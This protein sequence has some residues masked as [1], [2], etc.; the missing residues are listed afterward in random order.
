MNAE[1]KTAFRFTSR[2]FSYA[3]KVMSDQE[4][5]LLNFG[6]RE[7]HKKTSRASKTGQASS[8]RSL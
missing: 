7:K 8:L 1:V 3:L 5:P 6:C 4:R 2:Q